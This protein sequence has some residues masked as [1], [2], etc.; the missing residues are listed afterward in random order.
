VTFFLA[1][2]LHGLT[3]RL[4][5]VFCV[6]FAVYSLQTLIL[7]TASRTGTESIPWLSWFLLAF[8]RSLV[9]FM[10]MLVLVIVAGNVAPKA[11][12]RRIT[13]LAIAVVLGATIGILLMHLVE[14]GESLSLLDLARLWFGFCLVGGLGS[15][16]Y[17]LVA[18][19][20]EASA[21]LHEVEVGRAVLDKQMAEARL[22][23]MQ[24][25]IEP[26]FLFN[27]LANVRRLYRTDAVA[28]QVML[29]HLSH[30]LSAA[31]PRMRDP[32]TT[33][34]REAELTRAYLS[35]QQ[36]R[37]GRRLAFEIDVPEALQEASVPPM[38]L[39]TLV[40]NAIKHGLQ[41]LSQGGFVRV[42]ARA[43]D[44]QLRLTVAD[45]GRGFG[46]SSGTGVGLANIQARL[47]ALYGGAARL[48]LADNAPRGVSATI[49]LP[50]ST[51]APTRSAQSLAA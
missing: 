48:L 40:E 50:F 24:A 46:A 36:I 41:P 14:P 44:N 11:L 34:I 23:V 38:V 30:Y 35:V 19:G 8:G 37:M 12:P 22:Q 25:Q 6:I 7:M 20:A 15:A 1:R 31:L 5:A 39:V 18:R 32:G 17:L 28:G 47:V 51:V 2:C 27:T 13:A 9:R 29:R 21:A 43:N 33:L 42:S 16:I 10:P 49:E 4:W 26:H 45:T 3:W